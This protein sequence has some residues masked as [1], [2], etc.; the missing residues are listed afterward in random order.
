MIGLAQATEVLKIILGFGEV[1]SGK[2]WLFNAK[3]MKVEIIEFMSQRNT[4]KFTE[5]LREDI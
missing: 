1:L 3:A 2:L 4:E 5:D